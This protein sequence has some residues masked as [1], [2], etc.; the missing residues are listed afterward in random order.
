[1][2]ITGDLYK[3]GKK[4]V[5]KS[6]EII[7]KAFSEYPMF[8]NIL[9]DKLNHTNITIVLKFLIRQ[10]V[11]Y[12]E[13]YATSNNMEAIILYSDY[14][15]YN[16]G[17]ISSLR[18]GLLSL[19]KIGSDAGKRFNIFNEY[20]LRTHKENIKEPHQYV[21]LIGTDP[22]K[23]GQGYGSRLM[24]HILKESEEK[25][26][27]CYLETHGDKNVEFYKRLGFKVVSE[28][29]VPGTDIIQF[30]MLRDYQEVLST[31]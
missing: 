27:P 16:V 30:A 7:A 4:D 26:Q 18:S 31:E 21:I 6:A 13:A 8:Q 24:Q 9:G 2:L 17:L 12:G 28:G 25:G 5:N 15:D 20:S 22:N 3:L 29:A 11:L 23:Q 1:M 14:K 10:A 19:L